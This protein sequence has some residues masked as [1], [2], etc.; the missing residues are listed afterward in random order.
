M[1]LYH[2]L[3]YKET[4]QCFVSQEELASSIYAEVGEGTAGRYLS[5][6]GAHSDPAPYATT[7]LALQASKYASTQVSFHLE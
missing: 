2:F 3:G 5:T 7:T 4:K 1:A 6:F